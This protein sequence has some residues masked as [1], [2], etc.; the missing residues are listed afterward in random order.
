M[1]QFYLQMSSRAGVV[2]HGVAMVAACLTSHVFHPISALH[3]WTLRS[4]F[5]LNVKFTRK[6]K[7]KKKIEFCFHL[8]LPDQG[9]LLYLNQ[10][11]SGL[12]Y[13]GKISMTSTCQ[14]GLLNK[15]DV[16]WCWDATN[17]ITINYSKA[18][19]DM[20]MTDL[21]RVQFKMKLNTHGP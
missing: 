8:L 21:H 14:T 4:L 20:E 15:Q 11:V 9:H 16:K 10:L 6:E 18:Q 7:L 12:M 13:Y 2:V 3:S 5:F 19:D 17:H 1:C